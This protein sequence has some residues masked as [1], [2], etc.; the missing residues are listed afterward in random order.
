MIQAQKIAHGSILYAIKNDKNWTTEKLNEILKTRI[1]NYFYKT[2]KRK[3]III[4]S[5]VT[6]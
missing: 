1:R 5:L 4:P 2:K 3:P 6:I